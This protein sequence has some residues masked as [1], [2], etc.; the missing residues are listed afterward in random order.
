MSKTGSKVSLK[1]EDSKN[2]HGKK[3]GK[4]DLEVDEVE[5]NIELNMSLNDFYEDDDFNIYFD[6]AQ[7]LNHLNHL[8]DDNLFKINL[9]Q[10]DEANVKNFSE[11][12]AV[13]IDKAKKDI[14]DVEKSIT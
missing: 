5:E 10:D 3:G 14:E 2:K 4:S 6:K 7:L 9:L 13:K 8:E 12:A 1:S 11:E